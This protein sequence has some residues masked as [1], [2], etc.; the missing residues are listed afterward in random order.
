MRIFIRSGYLVNGEIV[1]NFDGKYIR[2]GYNFN[3]NVL[4]NL[5]GDYIRAGYLNNGDI[6]YNIDGKFIRSGYYSNG[7]ILYNIDGDYIRV[8]YLSNGEV[9]YN[10]TDADSSGG[11][12]VS[13]ACV[14]AKGLPDNCVELETLRR[15][16]DSWVVSHINGIEEIEDY[17][18][19]APVVVDNINRRSDAVHIYELIYTEVIQ[20][21]VNY[22]FVGQ[23]D[24]AYQLYKNSMLTLREHFKN[25]DLE[26]I[27]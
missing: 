9:V 14:R 23:N 17:Y 3:G 13:T 1:Y 8:G 2:A 11:C 12:I 26:H 10:I 25:A 16:R 24:K 15:F 18:T 22:I 19:F 7:D 4:Y 20:K 27:S 5:D 6:V 21:C